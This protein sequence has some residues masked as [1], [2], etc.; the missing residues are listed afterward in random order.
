MARVNRFRRA[1]EDLLAIAD[2]IAA[3]NPAAAAKWLDRIEG[4]LSLLASNPL[5]GEAVDSIRPRLRRF[6]QGSYVILYEP[7]EKGIDLVRVLHG[8]RRIE[9]LIE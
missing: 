1:E 3:D 8:S 4:T 2:R 6:C 9:D 5:M 7:R